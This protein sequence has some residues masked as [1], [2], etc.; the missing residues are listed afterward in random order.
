L[1]HSTQDL[2]RD[3]VDSARSQG[4]PAPHDGPTIRITLYKNGFVVGD[5]EFQSL[6]DPENVKALK[7]LKEG[8][9]S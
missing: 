4:N 6:D 1:Y 2:V 9:V 8:Y 3:I 5:G 7:E